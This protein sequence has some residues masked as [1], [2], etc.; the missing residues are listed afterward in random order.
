M[1]EMIAKCGCNCSK[2]PT[3]KNNLQ[4]PEDRKRCSW[5][6]EE[7]LNIRLSP[8]KLR[9]C[10]GCQVPDNQRKVYYLNCIVR[11]CAQSSGITNCA[12]CSVYPCGEVKH[13]HITFVENI[14]EMTAER[15]GREIPDKDYF[16]FI[17]PYEGIKKL[18]TIRKTLAR[19]EM[20]EP[21]KF[22][23]KSKMKGFPDKLLHSEKDG[24]IYKSLYDLL[25]RINGLVQDVPFAK[26]EALKRKRPYLNLLLWTFGLYGTFRKRDDTSLTIDSKDYGNQKNQRVY[27]KLKDYFE[28]FKVYGAHFELIPLDEKWLTSSGGLQIKLG[29]KEI[30]AW[31]MTLSFDSNL[32]GKKGLI[33]L[34]SYAKKLLA[35]YGEKSI[36]YFSK[37]DMEVLSGNDSQ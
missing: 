6:W 10:D 20:K 17:Q 35:K 16:D 30:P 25:A 24:S 26:R 32:S 2:C 7:Y 13:L 19:N 34:Q 5:G 1:D 33:A 28:I 9:L 21:K 14:R 31:I 4:T 22:H 18:D 8:E 37:S 15:I 27:S 3:Y 36:D 12:F 29:R 23:L 11:K